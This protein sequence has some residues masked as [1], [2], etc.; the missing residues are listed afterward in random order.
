VTGRGWHGASRLPR[1]KPGVAHVEIEGERVLYDPAT[2]AVARLNPVGAV[3][4][5]ALDGE[6]TVAD[7]A[8]DAASAFE[9]DQGDALAGVQRLLEQLDDEG[10]LAPGG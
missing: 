3:L 9:V 8:A 1:A 6:G 10:F 4:W 5:T 7:L 2:R